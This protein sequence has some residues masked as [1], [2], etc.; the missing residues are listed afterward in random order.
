MNIKSELDM[1]IK[2]ECKFE[3]NRIIF[4][5]RV[6]LLLKVELCIVYVYR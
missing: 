4:I 6:T 5:T 1:Q 3:V 2:F